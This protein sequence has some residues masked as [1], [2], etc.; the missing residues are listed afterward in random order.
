MASAASQLTLST[1]GVK[2]ATHRLQK[3]FGIAIHEALSVSVSNSRNLDE[4]LSYP[5][6]V[7]GKYANELWL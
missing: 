3:C 2:V 1:N 4:E 7:S 6:K 5:M